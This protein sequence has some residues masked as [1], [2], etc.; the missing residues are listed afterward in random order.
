MHVVVLG[1]ILG[2]GILL[3][4]ILGFRLLNNFHDFSR[5][6]VAVILIKSKIAR[7]KTKQKHS[8]VIK[9]CKSEYEQ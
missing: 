6:C 2:F 1:G 4:I 9:I 5:V 8:W 3:G 7:K